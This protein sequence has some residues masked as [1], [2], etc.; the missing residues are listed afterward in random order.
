MSIFL[1]LKQPPPLLFTFEVVRLSLT[2]LRT[3]E[4]VHWDE[5]AAGD[6]S[7]RSLAYLRFVV[8][9]S[10]RRAVSED[11]ELHTKEE[12]LRQHCTQGKTAA[13]KLLLSYSCKVYSKQPPRTN[14]C[15]WMGSGAR[16]KMHKQKSRRVETGPFPRP[17]R[18][19]NKQSGAAELAPSF[20]LTSPPLARTCTYGT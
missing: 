1:G 13:S 17:H 6:F 18:S 11:A 12:R 10:R 5:R 7:H 9:R 16:M 15:G 14:G 3:N 19:E 8:G 20:T 4:L 2:A